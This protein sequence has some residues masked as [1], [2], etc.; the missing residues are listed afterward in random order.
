MPPSLFEMMEL[1]QNAKNVKI[2]TLTVV[3]LFM[4]AR[5]RLAGSKLDRQKGKLEVLICASDIQLCPFS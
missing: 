4:Q 3:W 2:Q 5:S 1:V